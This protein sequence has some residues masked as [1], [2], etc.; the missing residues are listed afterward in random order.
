MIMIQTVQLSPGHHQAEKESIYQRM[1]T[2][3]SLSM[4]MMKKKIHIQNQ[5]ENEFHQTMR[6]KKKT[7]KMKINTIQK[8]KEANI[9]NVL[10]A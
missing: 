7:L 1:K 6:M 3:T 8:R 9:Q 4:V 2:K 10:K 5:K